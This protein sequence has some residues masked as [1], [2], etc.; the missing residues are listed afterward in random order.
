MARGDWRGNGWGSSSRGGSG[1]GRNSKQPCRFFQS[2]KCT[3]G[4]KCSYSH[5]LSSD[6]P[7]EGLR[8]RREET[9]E[10]QQA[11]AEYNTWRRI[12]KR[13][14]RANDIMTVRS[15]WTGALDIL[16]GDDREWKQRLPKDLDSDEFNGRHHIRT[17]MEME[18]HTHGSS[19]F[20]DLVLPFLQV[21]THPCLLDCISVDTAVGG[22]YNF[23]SGANGSRA[24][25][26]FNSVVKNLL[27]HHLESGVSSPSVDLEKTLIASLV[28]L[29]ELLT[30][31]QRAAFHDD[32]PTL[33]N[34]LENVAEVTGIDKQPIAS[35]LIR[36]KVQGL[37]GVIGRA[38]GL[39]RSEEEQE[40]TGVSTPAVT[41]TY[42]RN[43]ILPLNRHDNDKLDITRKKL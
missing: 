17:L 36:D 4:T 43:V 9:P 33:V 21:I 41:S 19:T 28:A 23:I 14:P 37:R 29:R 12:I 24:I 2:G 38:T 40:K 34:S 1:G 3:Y 11:K 8:Q 39:L 7:G 16:N 26:F 20:M 30:R 6:G 15:L 42:P 13:E 27:D 5:D 35:Q 31:E 25:L 10:Q 18:T 22:L 32:L